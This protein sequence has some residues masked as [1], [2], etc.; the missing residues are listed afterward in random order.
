MT[1]KLSNVAFIFVSVVVCAPANSF[2]TAYTPITAPAGATTWGNTNQS[3]STSTNSSQWNTENHSGYS[4]NWG[5]Q[6]TNYGAEGQSFNNTSSAQSLDSI[7]ANVYKTNQGTGNDANGSLSTT[8]GALLANNQQNQSQG[9]NQ[10]SN[11]NTIGSQGN[12]FF[13]QKSYDGGSSTSTH[14][15]SSQSGNTG[16]SWYNPGGFPAFSWPW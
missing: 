10:G 15:S 2:Y 13:N 8:L 5:E 6:S 1:F 4:A 7:L 3:Q 16:S 14:S 12:V 11:Y 9:N